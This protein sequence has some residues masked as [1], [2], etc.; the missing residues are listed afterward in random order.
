[1]EGEI[2]PASWKKRQNGDTNKPPQKQKFCGDLSEAVEVGL[3]GDIAVG[4]GIVDFFSPHIQ[5]EPDGQEVEIGD[6]DPDLYAS[7]HE[8]WSC[9]LPVGAAPFF[10]ADTSVNRLLPHNSRISGRIS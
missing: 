7:E 10:L 1:M 2:F 9:Q 6:A 5:N 4:F 8:Q 3:I